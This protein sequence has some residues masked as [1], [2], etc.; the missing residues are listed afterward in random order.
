MV[1][2]FPREQLR[3]NS[4]RPTAICDVL[5]ATGPR[6]Y[7]SGDIAL[8]TPTT[9]ARTRRGLWALYPVGEEVV[10]AHPGGA[11]A[12]PP[13]EVAATL[14]RLVAADG[15]EPLERQVV[16]ALRRFLVGDRTQ[17]RPTGRSWSRPA[18]G[19]WLSDPRNEPGRNDRRARLEPTRRPPAVPG[20]ERI[21]PTRPEATP[22]SGLRSAA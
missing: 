11:V 12:G 22:E 4:E 9:S 15:H 10:V 18:I 1:V 20:D 14:D 16:Q 17:V 19:Y 8:G 3:Y 6:S 5:L 2:H 7:R 21:R 13:A